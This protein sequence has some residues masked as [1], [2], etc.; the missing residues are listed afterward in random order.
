MGGITCAHRGMVRRIC[1]RTQFRTLYTSCGYNQSTSQ[2][3]V[4]SRGTSA[5]FHP[6]PIVSTVRRAIHYIRD[7]TQN[8]RSRYHKIAHHKFRKKVGCARRSPCPG[9]W[10][11]DTVSSR[12]FL[13]PTDPVSSTS[14]LLRVHRLL[15]HSII[16]P[17]H[18]DTRCNNV[19]WSFSIPRY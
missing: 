4:D 9:S 17:S 12:I 16:R 19:R 14:P 10:P 15:F 2:C 3:T 1:S 5:S 8:H 13:K 18:E 7:Q 11:S 6:L